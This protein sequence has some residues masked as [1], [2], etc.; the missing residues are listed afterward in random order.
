L[1]AFDGIEEDLVGLLDAFEER[2]VFFLACCCFLIGVMLEDL[3]TMGALDLV[4]SGTVSQLGKTEDGVVI[5][6]LS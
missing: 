2:V 5:L 3:L 4:L 6:T 1:A